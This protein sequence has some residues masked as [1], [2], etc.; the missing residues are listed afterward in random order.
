MSFRLN[1]PDRKPFSC[2][3]HQVQGK[4][5]VDMELGHRRVVI[6]KEWNAINVPDAG[7]ARD[8]AQKPVRKL[9]SILALPLQTNLFPEQRPAT[10]W[11]RG[12]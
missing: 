10:R 8:A 11:Y 12:V 7:K 9:Q 3:S 4:G 1:E 2:H 5:F 6:G